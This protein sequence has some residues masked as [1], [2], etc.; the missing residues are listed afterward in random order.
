MIQLKPGLSP[1]S[2]NRL[3]KSSLRSKSRSSKKKSKGLRFERVFSDAKVAPFDQVDWERRTAEITDDSGKVIFKQE[4]IEVPKSWS[5]LATKIAVSKYFYGDIANGTDPHQGGRETSVRQ[6]VHRV[7]RTIA[8]WGIADG[9]FADAQAAQIF[10]DELTWLCV[11][12]HGAFNSPVWFNVG[13]HHQYGIGRDG[14]LGNY[15]YNRTTGQ[16]ERASTQYEY[17]QG[18]ACFIQSVGDTM[19]DIMRLATS[20]AML[21]K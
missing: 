14:G 21:F 10:Y 5:A 12:Q 15:F 16:A 8:D 9:Y 3:R 6:L 20:E 1:S 7:T 17:P 2:L 19:E 13:L 11:N 18:S 4:N